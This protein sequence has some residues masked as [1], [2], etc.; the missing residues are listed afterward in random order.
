M[1]VSAKHKPWFVALYDILCPS[2]PDNP[3]RA[4]FEQYNTINQSINQSVHYS[5]GYTVSISTF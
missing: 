2:K 4:A 3:S 5:R 1:A